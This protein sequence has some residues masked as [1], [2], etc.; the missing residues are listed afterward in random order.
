MRVTVPG[1]FAL[2]LAGCAAVPLPPPPEA[3]VGGTDRVAAQ[4]AAGQAAQPSPGA[5]RMLA[6]VEALA[7]A[8]NAEILAALRRYEAA[9]GREE[10]AGLWPNPSVRLEVRDVPRHPIAIDRGGQWVEV[11]QPIAAG[12][13]IGAGREAATAE[14]EALGWALAVVRRRVAAD[15]RSACADLTAAVA[16]R[17]VRAAIAADAAS[18]AES[19]RRRVDQGMS[20]EADAAILAIEAERATSELR[21]SEAACAAATAAVRALTGDAA[22]AP[23]TVEWPAETSPSVA[24]DPEAHPAMRAAAAQVAAADRRVDEARA[25]RVPDVSVSVAYGRVGEDG[26]EFVEGAVEVPLPVFDRNQGRIRE[27][28]ALA[29]AARAE[30]WRV[31]RDLAR[32]REAATA[33]RAAAAADLAAHRDRIVP[34]A[35]RLAEQIVRAFDAGT[36]S[37]TD[38]ALARRTASEARLGLVEAERAFRRAEAELLDVAGRR[39]GEDAQ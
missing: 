33:A 26:E 6:D 37:A 13:R 3:F 2:A 28:E 38:A 36:R 7:Q 14:R 32:R 22:E 29:S 23:A 17:R 8:N 18:L 21:R 27:A 15:V 19:A 10:Q 20:S 24:E 12:G 34:A 4:R 35:E 9:G 31:R 39:A 16:S 11:T 1:S 30:E 5:T 25:A